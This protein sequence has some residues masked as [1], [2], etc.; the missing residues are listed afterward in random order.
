[1]NG[2]AAKRACRGIARCFGVLSLTAAL[3]AAAAGCAAPA[4]GPVPEPGPFDRIA[5]SL[6][7]GGSACFIG[8]ADGAAAAFDRLRRDTERKI[9]SSGMPEQRRLEMQSIISGAELFARI[10]GLAEV[11]GWGCS[12]KRTEGGLF[13]NRFRLLLGPEPRGVLWQLPG[14]ENVRLSF[15][16]LPEDTISAGIA[17][18]DAAAAQRLLTIDKRATELADGLCKLFLGLTA[19]DLLPVVSGTWKFVIVGDEQPDIDSFAGLYG[20]LTV[21]DRGGKLFAA[22][23]ARAGLLSGARVDKKAGIV[24]LPPVPGRNLAPCVR[25]G[26]GELTIYSSPSA[27]ERTLRKQAPGLR[28]PDAFVTGV[29]A[30]YNA[31]AEGMLLS[32]NTPPSG[33]SSLGVLMRLPD[34]FLYEEYSPCDL[35]SYAALSLGALPARILFDIF[36]SA[37]PAGRKTP[38][39]QGAP[40]ARRAPK[41]VA[42]AKPRG[43]AAVRDD[44]CLGNIAAVGRDL[45]KAA[46]PRKAF[47]APGISGLRELVRTKKI[48]P[49]GLVCPVGLKKDAGEQR[50]LSYANCHYLY[51]GKPAPD[52]PKSPLLMELPFRHRD[53]IAVFYADGSCEKIRLPEHRNVR[54]AVSFLHTRHSY[55][56]EEFIRL[57]NLAAEFDKILEL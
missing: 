1:M 47:P 21:P 51:F 45:L 26:A 37:P 43:S 8:T 38:R 2:T 29:A 57:M 31:N 39:P 30:F 19:K 6:D 53:H 34:G 11:R 44:R 41:K 9:W 23:C 36:A 35:N 28:E 25:K 5:A 4:P 12:S 55:E 49:A 56:E 50:E 10:A 33:R 27:C 48:R 17:H 13:R 22:L 54:R 20:F 15:G 7:F 42:P 24:Q 46:G 3:L 18:I 40:P 16:R 32:G 14:K 52:S